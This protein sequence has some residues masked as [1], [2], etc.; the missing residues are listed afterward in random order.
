MTGKK[1]IGQDNFQVC[2]CNNV[3][4][5][6]TH[7]C[8]VIL[9]KQ[10]IWSLSIFRFLSIK[11]ILLTFTI[12]QNYFLCKLV[13]YI[14]S[15]VSS[16]IGL[17]QK[18]RR[19]GIFRIIFEGCISSISEARGGPM[20][21]KYWQWF[22]CHLPFPPSTLKRREVFWIISC[23]N[24]VCFKNWTYNYVCLANR[25]FI[26]GIQFDLSKLVLRVTH[27]SVFTGVLFLIIIYFWTT[28]I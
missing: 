1:G 12:L 16:S 13:R 17:K 8:H 4:F 10:L 19:L 5:V 24:D 6:R 27:C 3:S 9:L 14:S 21:A 18:V 22:L 23:L 2:N 26:L 25:I 7:T 11:I 20:F 28:S 15:I